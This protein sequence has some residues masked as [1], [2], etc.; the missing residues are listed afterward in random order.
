M[1]K[2]SSEFAASCSNHELHCLLRTLFNT[3]SDTT[4]PQ[5]ERHCCGG[6]IQTVRKELAHPAR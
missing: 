4:L 5:P 1:L 3:L 6:S 2:V